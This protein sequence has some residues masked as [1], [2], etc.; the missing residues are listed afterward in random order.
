MRRECFIGQSKSSTG[1]GGAVN[2]AASSRL[3][4]MLNFSFN[5]PVLYA[6][7]N[8]ATHLIE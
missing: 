3:V 7:D 5:T 1:N 2:M 6:F 4:T 8:F